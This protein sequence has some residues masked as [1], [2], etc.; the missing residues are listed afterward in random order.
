MAHP[1]VIQGLTAVPISSFQLAIQVLAEEDLIPELFKGLKKQGVDS[2]HLSFAVMEAAQ[3]LIRTKHS[4][5]LLK[6]SANGNADK[7][8]QCAGCCNGCD[9]GK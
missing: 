8:V 6:A 4:S 3:E 2:I 1:V 5:G 7:I 9:I